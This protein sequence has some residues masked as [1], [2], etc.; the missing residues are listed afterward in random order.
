VL[1]ISAIT[2]LLDLYA[3]GPAPPCLDAA[4]ANNDGRYNIVDPVAILQKVLG[5][6][7]VTIPPPYEEVGGDTGSSLGCDAFPVVTCP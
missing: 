3:G 1:L 5:N 7:D 4:D 2:S 6:P